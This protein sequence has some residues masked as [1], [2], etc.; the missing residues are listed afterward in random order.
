V[1]LQLNWWFDH[2]RTV[3]NMNEEKLCTIAHLKEFF[4]A[5]QEID[6]TGA[7][8]DSD[9]QS[10]ELISHVLKR[11]FILSWQSRMSPVTSRTA[12]TSK[13]QELWPWIF[14]RY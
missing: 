4:N 3:I 13:G 7:R 14:F 12:Q 10:Y 9:H 11:L 2:P 1:N 5:T 8:S 6:F